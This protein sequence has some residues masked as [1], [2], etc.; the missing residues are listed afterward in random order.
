M[1]IYAACY[2]CMVTQALTA[3]SLNHIDDATQKKVV[4]K[5][6]KLLEVADENLPPSE[7]AGD[8]NQI[9]RDETGIADF[10][11]AIKRDSTKKAL[12]IYPRLKKL[13]AE[14]SSPV[15]LAL[16]ISAAGN[17][18]DVIHSTQFDMDHI[19][20]QIEGLSFIGDG[21]TAFLEKLERAEYLLLLADNAGETIFD[22]VLIETLPIPVKYAVKS[23][24]IL[25]DAT[26]SD[27]I[28]SGL[29]GI[30]ELVESGA[31]G[32]GTT[33]HQ[34]SVSFRALMDEA[35]LILAKGQ[36]NFE[37]LEHQPY[38]HLYLM[39]KTK[40]PIIARHLKLPQEHIVLMHA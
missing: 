29:E 31:K 24:P 38:E 13:V 14:S 28:D 18:I 30:A 4:R 34:C 33:L 12:E 11:A 22:R 17:A 1:N 7:I 32:P 39:F 20:N 8:T 10:Y 5:I 36:A 2:A 9:I 3:M 19:I 37:T 15:E 35:P 40:C 6:M 16:R 21:Y 25:N 27:A 23:G 26:L